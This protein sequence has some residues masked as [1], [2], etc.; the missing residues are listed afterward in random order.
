VYSSHLLFICILQAEREKCYNFPQI[1]LDLP[2]VEKNLRAGSFSKE[3]VPPCL[4]T[5]E[6]CFLEQILHIT[7]NNKPNT[8][9]RF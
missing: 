9:D 7:Y 2:P 5:E 8:T 3:E 1:P 4:L 6:H